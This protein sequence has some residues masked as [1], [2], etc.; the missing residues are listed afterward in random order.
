MLTYALTVAQPF[1]IECK[2]FDIERGT[3]FSLTLLSSDTWPAVVDKAAEKFLKHP[4]ALHLQYRFSNEKRATLPF[5]LDSEQAFHNLQDK[6]EQLQILPS[7]T[8]LKRKTMRKMI[9]VQ[10]YNK[11]ATGESTLKGKAKVSKSHHI[12]VGV[13]TNFACHRQLWKL[14]L[15]PTLRHPCPRL[16]RSM[17]RKRRS[18]QRSTRYGHANSTLSLIS[19]SCAGGSVTTTAISSD[20]AILLLCRMLTFGPRYR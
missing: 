8:V 16:M 3:R 12:L 19:Q 1:K 9:L 18:P 2:V 7:I 5:N 10:L 20:R 13:W 14:Q 4:S 17:W 11:N 15:P 6:Y